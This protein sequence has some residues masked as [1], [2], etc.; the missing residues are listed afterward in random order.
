M[1]IIV[2]A[3]PSSKEDIVEK[4]DEYTYKVSVKAPPLNGKA[5]AAIVKVLSEYFKTSPSLVEIISGYRSKTKVV[6]IHK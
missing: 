4:I 2:K 5:N 3:K 6:E 1:K